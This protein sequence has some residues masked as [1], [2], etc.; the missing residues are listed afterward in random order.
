M[1]RGRALAALALAVLFVLA[2]AA[3]PETPRGPVGAWMAS[4]GLA[5]RLETVDGLRV[6]YVRAGSGP[7]V[8]L[9]HGFA[10][11][12]YTW[13]D[14]IPALARAHDVV[15]FDLPGYGGSDQPPHLT[16]EIYP[17]VIT[18][19]MSRLGLHSA[20]LVGNSLGGGVCA[21][22]AGGSP[23]RVERL[24]LIDSAG[25]NLAEGERP[26]MVRLAAS[27]AAGAVIGRLPV[28]RFFVR[29]ALLQ[30]F[31]D[32][33]LVTPERV[34]EYVAPLL[35]PG[36]LASTQSLLASRGR[37]TPGSFRDAVAR[38]R[39]PTLIVWGREDAWIPLENADR[40]AA[41]IPGSRKVVLD[42]C[43]HM[44]QEERPREVA[45]LLETFLDAGP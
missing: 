15:A 42:S 30:V 40:F 41:A 26:W 31:H 29:A 38:V 11:S 19:L 37:L 9:V 22:V 6:R 24:A 43:G 5:P 36:A 25:F 13:K 32:D 3:M 16:P 35:R 39:V 20:S 8:V 7:A 44:P 28:R 23:E 2:L 45:Q 17:N 4:S 14:V 12:I 18:G 21:L 10:S 27:K 1:R 33:A 34:D